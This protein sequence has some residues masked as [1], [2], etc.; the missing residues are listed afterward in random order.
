MSDCFSLFRL[1]EAGLL[2]SWVLPESSASWSW[3]KSPTDQGTRL[4]ADSSGDWEETRGCWP[5]LPELQVLESS[6]VWGSFSPLWCPVFWRHLVTWEL[7]K[8]PQGR[9]LQGRPCL[10]F[11]RKRQAWLHFTFDILVASAC[12]F[13]LRPWYNP[14]NQFID[15]FS[16]FASNR[17]YQT[18]NKSQKLLFS[19]STE[20]GNETKILSFLSSSPALPSSSPISYSSPFL[21]VHIPKQMHS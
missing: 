16:K 11:V 8:T 4:S 14:L 6:R 3:L 10:Y 12:H 18:L 15:F 19:F 2:N 9:I 21:Y 5:P 13:K 17:I 7:L 20:M 1:L